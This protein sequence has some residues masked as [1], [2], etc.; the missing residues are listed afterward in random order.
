MSS[1]LSGRE[2]FEAVWQHVQTSKMRLSA[3]ESRTLMELK[4]AWENDPAT[5]TEL[6]ALKQLHTGLNRWY[7][8]DDEIGA[9]WKRYIDAS[10]RYR[11]MR[12]DLNHDG[13]RPYDTRR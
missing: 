2:E 4:R 9:R 6:F 1:D 11:L 8:Q 12:L 5:T 10:M 3:D 7:N 13:P